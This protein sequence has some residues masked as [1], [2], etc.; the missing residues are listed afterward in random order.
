MVI[1]LQHGGKVPFYHG[2]LRQQVGIQALHLG[3]GGD[4][5]SVSGRRLKH[6]LNVHIPEE[7][8]RL[9]PP[10]ILRQIHLNRAHS[11]GKAFQG[12]LRIGPDGVHICLRQSASMIAEIV[13]GADDKVG[14]A[15]VAQVFVHVEAS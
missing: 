7:V 15:L 10:D 11:I 1:R 2:E 8:L 4:F 5:I 12:P 9:L 3:I 14:A 13:R 6:F